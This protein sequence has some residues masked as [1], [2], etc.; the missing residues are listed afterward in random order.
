MAPKHSARRIAPVVALVALA[1]CQD[2]AGPTD[3]VAPEA[4][5]S[6]ARSPQA[7]ARLEQVFQRISP[8]V[9]DLPGTV[10]SDNDER[11]GK[12]V[13]GVDNM[14]AARGIQNAMK[15]LGIA[16]ADYAIELT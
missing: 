9:M 12:V 10:F 13:I 4:S 8:E 7:Q 6:A 1:A 5:V 11:I 2:A 14:G 15:R 16:D 3:T